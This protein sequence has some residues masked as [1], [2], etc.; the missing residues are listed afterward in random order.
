MINYLI[1]ILSL[2]IF[3]PPTQFTQAQ[4]TGTCHIRNNKMLVCN[5]G[6]YKYPD[7]TC[8][9]CTNAT[10]ANIAYKT[11]PNLLSVQCVGVYRLPGYTDW[12][13]AGAMYFY[14]SGKISG[15]FATG[16]HDTV[17]GK[18]CVGLKYLGFDEEGNITDCRIILIR[19]LE[20]DKPT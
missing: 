4:N 9:E 11:K 19:Q 1:L 3:I 10:G 17:S 5:I 8:K 12:D 7:G 13:W 20:V 2:L 6:M 15:C 18:R 14:P 16:V